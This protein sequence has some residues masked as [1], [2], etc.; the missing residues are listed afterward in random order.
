MDCE[1][2][3]RA[4]GLDADGTDDPLGLVAHGLIFVV[5]Q[6]LLGGHGDGVAGVHAHGVEVLDR[7]DDD[8]VVGT[9]AHHFELE[10]APPGDR[11]LDQDTV[12]RRELDAAADDLLQLVTVVGDTS[13]R[14]AEGEGWPHDDGI[15][16]LLDD[17]QGIVDRS[18]VA[19]PGHLNADPRHRLLEELAILGGLDGVVVRAD[20]LNV[21]AL[22][23][24]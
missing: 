8:H 13:A 14:S 23:H 18:G 2:D 10:L 19:R 20:Q 22:E 17:S 16:D 3:V 5:G 12:N 24:P 4:T 1:L 6:S 11:L 9:V 7:A 15:A 21:V